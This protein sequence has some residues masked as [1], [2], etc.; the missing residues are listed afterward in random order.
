MPTP[1]L[2]NPP[3]RDRIVD[4]DGKPTL[5]FSKWLSNLTT[6]IGA[7]ASLEPASDSANSTVSVTSTD[8]STV[9]GTATTGGD[10]FLN[11]AEMNTAIAN[12]NT[13][14]TLSNELKVDVNTLVIDLNDL[15]TKLRAAG[16]IA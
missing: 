12:I 1:I 2:G 16:V 14:K 6:K 3:I 10:G 13:I 11:A 9:T 5:G 15:K 4:E 8:A 7:L